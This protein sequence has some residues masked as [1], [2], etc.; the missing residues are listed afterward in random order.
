MLA[1]A[2]PAPRS[3]GRS[4]TAGPCQDLLVG[5]AVKTPG[6]TQTDRCLPPNLHHGPP[7]TSRGRLDEF[8]EAP[9]VSPEGKQ[10]S[11]ARFGAIPSELGQTS[12]KVW[13]LLG[14]KEPPTKP[15]TCGFARCAGWI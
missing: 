10:Q 12:G 9:K 14:S 7:G 5:S 1:P 8:G 4:R 2:R 3:A 15:L 11:G 6:P 13:R